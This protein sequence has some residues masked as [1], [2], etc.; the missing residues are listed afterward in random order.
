MELLFYELL[1]LAPKSA[2]I[3]NFGLRYVCGV[4]RYNTIILNIYFFGF[5]KDKEIRQWDIE[6]C[7]DIKLVMEQNKNLGNKLTNVR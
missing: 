2:L 4:F 3:K 1:Q 5:F 6:N 7:D